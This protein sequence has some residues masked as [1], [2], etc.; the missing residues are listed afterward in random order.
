M[1]RDGTASQGDAKFGRGCE[2]VGK[3]PFNRSGRWRVL[4]E[5]TRRKTNRPSG[6]RWAG[7]DCEREA[8]RHL[9]AWEEGGGAGGMG[10]L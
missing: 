7:G 8:G 10:L 9:E 6:M 5:G 2:G 3:Y 4:V 1:F